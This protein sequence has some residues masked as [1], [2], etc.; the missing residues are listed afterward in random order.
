[1]DWPEIEAMHGRRGV[2]IDATVGASHRV[3]LDPRLDGS[4]INSDRE[5]YLF[6]SRLLPAHLDLPTTQTKRQQV[7]S[8]A[9]LVVSK[10]RNS[11]YGEPEDN[12][13]RIAA[14]W[15]AYLEKD[16][17]SRDVA[18]L[19]VLLKVAREVHAPHP[20]NPVDVAGYAACA[21]EVTP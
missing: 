1:M 14:M 3:R 2:V 16:I 13:G 6:P 12:F 15:S 11:T 10:D 4:D 20:D 8:A 21:A 18:W 5:Y 9:E 19:M 17:T 7:L